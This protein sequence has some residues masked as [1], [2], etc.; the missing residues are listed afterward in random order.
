MK[1]TRWLR[2]SHQIRKRKSILKNR[3]FWIII[4]V[5]IILGGIFYLLFFSEVF[6]V[7]KIIIIGEAKVPKENIQILVERNL[8]NKILFFKTKNIFLINLKKIKRAILNNFPQIAEVKIIRRFPDALNFVI[9]ER[10]KSA[11][12]CQEEN[13]FLIGNEGVIFEKVQLKED[14]IKIID[15]QNRTPFDLGNEVIEKKL[16]SQ[17]LDVESKLKKDL[18]IQIKEVSIIS[19][20]RLNFKTSEDW[21]IYLNPQKDIDWQLL[22]LKAV[23]EEYIPSEKRSDLEYIELRFGDLAPFKYKD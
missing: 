7:K 6:Q 16:L 15:K 9:R 13:C 2:R 20:E 5:F 11:Y 8:E 21:E 12:W 22:K 3:L 10:I 19:G 14:L 17:I 4:F 1:K 18:N 23:L